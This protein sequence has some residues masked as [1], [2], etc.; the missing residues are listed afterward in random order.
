MSSFTKNLSITQLKDRDLWR[1]DRAFKYH[2]GSEKSKDTINIPEGFV[3]NGASI[4]RAF[5][6]IVG[7]PFAEYA[8]AAVLH[9][10][11][12]KHKLFWRK[13]CD[14][15]FLEA[16]EVLKVSWIKRHTMYR[17]VRIFGWIPWRK[18]C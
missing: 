8:Q 11:M 12:Y 18:E 10:Y 3:T 7:H 9:D 17:A 14:K 15:L 6:S 4:P 16:M 13:K 5:W 1:V 2:I